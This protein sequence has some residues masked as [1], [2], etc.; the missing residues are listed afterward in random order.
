MRVIDL[1]A[2]PDVTLNYFSTNSERLRAFCANNEIEPGDS[3]L[4]VSRTDRAR[5]LE[6]KPQGFIVV[7]LVEHDKHLSPMVQALS[8]Y[9]RRMSGDDRATTREL[10]RAAERKI[11]RQMRRA[12]NK[13]KK[14][15]GKLAL[16]W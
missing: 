1:N 16:D 4:I 9:E 6:Y 15:N 7:Q 3:V 8:H 12:D 10:R 13:E 5:V 14:K 11:R 2:L